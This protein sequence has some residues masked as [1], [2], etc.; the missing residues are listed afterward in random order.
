[1][2]ARLRTLCYDPHML[3]LHRHAIVVSPFSKPFPDPKENGANDN[4]EHQ[5]NKDGNNREYVHGNVC[6]G[7]V[8]A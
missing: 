2:A 4:D 6:Q 7:I 5:T 8:G 3:R 1:M